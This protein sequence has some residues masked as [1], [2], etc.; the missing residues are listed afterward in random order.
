MN[1]GYVDLHCHYLPGIDDGV[2]TFEE[3]VALCRGLRDIG[4]R[5]VVATPHIRTAM[6]PNTKAG[7]RAASRA[8][9]VRQ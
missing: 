7:L 4:Y 2:R 3:G 6:F 8:D 9:R 1:T 5:R